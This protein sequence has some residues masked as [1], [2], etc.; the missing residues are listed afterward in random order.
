[1]DGHCCAS[2][3]D[4]GAVPPSPVSRLS[5]TASLVLLATVV[6]VGGTLW[7][8]ASL[9]VLCRPPSV[10]LSAA[11][12]V[13]GDTLWPSVSLAVVVSAASVVDNNAVASTEEDDMEAGASVDVVVDVVAAVVV[14]TVVVVTVVSAENEVQV[15]VESSDAEDEADNDVVVSPIANLMQTSAPLCGFGATCSPAMDHSSQ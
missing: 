14:V 4:E 2:S 11:A 9:E 1:M 6:V 15:V 13:V 5:S 12:V 8:S 7:P 3:C 10:V